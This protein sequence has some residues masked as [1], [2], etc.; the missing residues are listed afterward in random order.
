MEENEDSALSSVVARA[1]ALMQRRRQGFSPAQEGGDLPVLTE[2]VDPD[3]DLPVLLAVETVAP[4]ALIEP[5]PPTPDPAV[6]EILAHELAR[7]MGE[8]LADEIP[9][10]VATALQS[11][12]TG[13]TEELRQGLAASTEAAIRDFLAER[14]T[15]TQ[16]QYQD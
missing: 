7:R 5:E 14:E 8:R 10:L 12:L 4:T 13:V 1:D 2:T 11:A 9:G 6:L 3:D 16:I 15:L